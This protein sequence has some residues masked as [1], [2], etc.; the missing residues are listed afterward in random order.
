MKMPQF[1]RKYPHRA[2]K[3]RKRKKE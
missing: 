2:A 3:E 1:N